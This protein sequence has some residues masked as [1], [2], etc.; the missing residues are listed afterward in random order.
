MPNVLILN[1]GRNQDHFGPHFVMEALIEAFRPIRT[2][3]VGSP[4]KP[5][6]LKDI[7]FIVVNAEGSTHHGAAPWLYQDYGIPSVMINAVWQKNPPGIDLSHFKYIAAREHRSAEAIRE[8]GVECAVVP[9]LMLS[10]DIEGGEGN[11]LVISNSVVDRA[12]GY[13]PERSNLARFQSAD[14]IAA[15]R[16]HVACLAIMTGKPFACYPSN[17]WKIEGMLEDAGLDCFYASAA[18][19]VDNCPTEPD[20]KAARYLQDARRRIADMIRHVQ[21]LAGIDPVPTW[22][23]W[24][25]AR[26]LAAIPFRKI[27]GVQRGRPAI[28]LCGG[29]SLPAQFEKVRESAPDAVLISANHHGA[30]YTRC[31]YIVAN[32]VWRKFY[33]RM[34]QFETPIIGP[35]KDSDFRLISYPNLGNT[36]MQAAWVAFALGC[37]PI[38]IAGADCFAGGTYWHD[39]SQGS[40]GFKTPPSTHADVWRYAMQTYC[41]IEIMRA[42]GGPLVDIL[43]EYHPDEKVEQCTER[44]TGRILAVGTKI[45]LLRNVLIRGEHFG[46][47]EV[48]EVCEQDANDL[49]QIGKARL[50][51]EPVGV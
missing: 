49:I 38:I 40:S 13:S 31:D 48:V 33:P 18:A 44:P 51:V 16:F 41:P 29:P 26:E 14:R 32:D 11:G 35:Y 12:A 4:P 47:D 30:M 1:D 23:S 9:D 34:M 28:V 3:P 22:S 20:P 24:P 46:T 6:D 25:A 7:D 42:A 19:A 36:G 37:S 5:S 45:E 39:E 15:G 50:Y 8:L 17:T 43:G 10:R 2:V 21:K 27:E